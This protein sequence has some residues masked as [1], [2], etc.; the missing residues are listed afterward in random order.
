MNFF[1]NYVKYNQNLK[2]YSTILKQFKKITYF[3]LALVCTLPTAFK[4]QHLP[5]TLW[6]FGL[7]FFIAGKE[8]GD[9]IVW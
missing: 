3:G 1:S 2:D 4:G 5:V 6:P 9:Q 8:Q 7:C